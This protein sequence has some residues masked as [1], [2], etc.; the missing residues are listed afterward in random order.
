MKGKTR[1]DG[2][3]TKC[4]D[5]FNYLPRNDGEPQRDRC[6]HCTP[7]WVFAKAVG[8]EEVEVQA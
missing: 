7:R 8:G 6:F 2:K 3:C 1:V 4:G 5:K